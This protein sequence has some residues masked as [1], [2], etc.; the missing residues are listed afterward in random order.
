MP[1]HPVSYL[2][3]MMIAANE[4][5]DDYQARRVGLMCGLFGGPSVLLSAMLAKPLADRALADTPAPVSPPPP[6]VPTQV[7]I[8]DV[9]GV[10]FITA[11]AKIENLGLK[12]TK[13][14]AFSEAA[15]GTVFDHN[16]PPN[17]LA[18]SGSTVSLV[19]S[20]GQ[21]SGGSAVKPKT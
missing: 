19:V 17:V 7:Q 12:V 15:A 4:G 8:P 18:A 11:K 20:K 9:K 14:D 3:G 1:L 21:A 6:H 13:V 5:V 10:L 16:P 2:V